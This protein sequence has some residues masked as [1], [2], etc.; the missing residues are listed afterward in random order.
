M[1]RVS[2]S[3]IG[4]LGDEAAHTGA[5]QLAVHAAFGLGF[6][7]FRS[8]DGQPVAELPLERARELAVKAQE[9]GL[10]VAVLASA[11]GNWARPVTGAFE[12]DLAELDRLADLAPI[13]GTTDV[14]VMAYPNDGLSEVDWEREVL[15]RFKALAGRARDRGLRLLVENCSGWT[16][17]DP[18]RFLA[19]SA[20]AGGDV[21]QC[22]FDI[23]NP[24]VYRCDPAAY[25]EKV[26]PAVAHVHVKDARCGPAGVEFTLPGQ[27]EAAVGACVD[28]L[29]AAG[30][31]GRFSLEPHLARIPHLGVTADASV[32][33]EHYRAYVRAF[34]ALI[35]PAGMAAG[36]T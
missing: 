11:I 25:L 14:R 5:A 22:L 31:T 2:R 16:A 19:L 29:L 28:R 24:I 10:E 4:G 1:S 32:L 26:L 6:L 23:G 13:F 7:E 21:V 34:Q 12:T 3:R 20:H 30:Y 15:R 36:A 8:V 35:E 27:G 18:E 33:A 17:R 9:A